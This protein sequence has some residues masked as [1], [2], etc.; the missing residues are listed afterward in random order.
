MNAVVRPSRWNGVS[1]EE[2]DVVARPSRYNGVSWNKQSMKRAALLNGINLGVHETED[3]AA[4][5]CSKYLEDGID[6]MQPWRD[7]N[8]SKLK[9]VSFHK[10]SGKWRAQCKGTYQGL[11]STEEAAALAFNEAERILHVIRPAGAARAGSRRGVGGGAGSKRA[12]TPTSAT[13]VTSKKT[14]L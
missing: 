2:E 3:E 7:A 4:R 1:W 9:G 14:K 12:A 13:R 11:H 6:P 10:A 5:A 8:T